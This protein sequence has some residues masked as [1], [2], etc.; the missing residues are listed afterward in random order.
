MVPPE[1]DARSGFFNTT[2]WSLLFAAGHRA[3]PS[4]AHAAVSRLCKIYWR[5]IYRFIRNTGYPARAGA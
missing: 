2:P 4:V 3:S 1:R 5:P